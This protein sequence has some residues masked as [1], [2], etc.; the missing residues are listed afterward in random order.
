MKIPY[1]PTMVHSTFRRRVG[2]HAASLYAVEIGDLTFWVY[3]GQLVKIK[4][5]SDTAREAYYLKVGYIGDLFPNENGKDL[6]DIH[7]MRSHLLRLLSLESE[8]IMLPAITNY[9]QGEK[10]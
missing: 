4:Y 5:L 3:D 6:V 8:R 9:L 10:K 7:T 1:F 2:T